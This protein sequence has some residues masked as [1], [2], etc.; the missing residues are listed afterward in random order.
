[1]CLMK[2]ALAL[3]RHGLALASVLAVAAEAADQGASTLDPTLAISQYAHTAWRVEDG[4]CDG[5][6]NAVTQTPDGY[7]WVGTDDG[8][9]RFDGV[10]FVRWTSP[11]EAPAL[12]WPVFSLLGTRDG[13]LWIGTGHS[14][15]RW[16]GTALQ[17]FPELIGRFNS[18]LEGSD[19]VIWAVRSRL[20][21]TRRSLRLGRHV[22][23]PVP[24]EGRRRVAPQSREPSAVRLHLRGR[25]RRF[26]RPLVV[27]ALRCD[28]AVGS[29]RRH[30]VGATTRDGDAARV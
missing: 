5:A 25:S 17:Q 14:I 13:S 3:L 12:S 28:S 23:R 7:L 29:G 21:T 18:I 2:R 4:A 6:P 11:A 15:V 19:R 27:C 9:V 26:W 1:V 16:D 8:V 22:G 24:L 10:R 30:V 20:D